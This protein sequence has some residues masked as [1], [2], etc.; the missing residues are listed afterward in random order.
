MMDLRVGADAKLDAFK[1]LTTPVEF[2]DLRAA[3]DADSW[4]DLACFLEAMWRLAR[5]QTSSSAMLDR[6]AIWFAWRGVPESVFWELSIRQATKLL[7]D[8]YAEIQ[9]GAAAQPVA[10][11]KELE[12][13]PRQGQK[14][15]V[16][17]EGQPSPPRLPEGVLHV[18]TES[19]SVTWC[20]QRYAFQHWKT[21]LFFKAL[22]QR[23]EE[24]LRADEIKC[25][26]ARVDRLLRNV[27]EALRSLIESA[28]CP[29]GGYR[30]RVSGRQVKVD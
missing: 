29:G 10:L 9:A 6:I 5:L 27:P 1:D 3:L 23:P 22:A 18:H 7:E 28:A 30:L 15:L 21:F 20:G 17:P 24:F 14:Y 13:P 19:Q 4:Y 12:P 2:K 26:Y 16:L 25:G 8:A 11:P